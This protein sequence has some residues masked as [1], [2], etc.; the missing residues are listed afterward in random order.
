MQY[1][2]REEELTKQQLNLEM[3]LEKPLTAAGKGVLLSSPV[4]KMDD[5]LIYSD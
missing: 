5:V 4:I 1:D 3:S 2:I